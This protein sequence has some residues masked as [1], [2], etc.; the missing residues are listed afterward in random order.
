LEGLNSSGFQITAT[1]PI[2]A[3]Q[4]WRMLSM[5][6][7]SLTS[8]I[9]L[10]CR[11]R[12]ENAPSI[13]RREYLQI[14]KRE[15]PQAIGVMQHTNLAPVDMAQATIG[16]GMG[17]FSRYDKIMEQD[18][19]SMTVRT[20]LT[21]INRT[22]DE[23]LAEQEGDFD[24][25]TRWAIAW[26]EQNQF[27][28]GEFGDAD[29]LCRAKNSAVNALV[30]AGIVQSGGG[31]VNLISRD[32]LP[33]K[34]NP[35]EDNHMV[36]WEITQHLIKQLQEN[37]ETGAARLYKK[38]GIKADVAREL[39]YRLFTICE[40]KGWSQEAQAYNSLVLSWNQIVAESYNIKESKP[41]QGN[42]FD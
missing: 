11:P 38:I 10:A 39:A 28:K 7:N 41:I 8:Y 32:V 27:E 30:H 42:L 17:I 6:T 24:S 2:K 12:P 29:A 9:V 15:L 22:L 13:T 4:K 36:I 20:A 23:L 26:F 18:G 19:S 31:K 33:E 14:L 16:P 5:G 1:W 34:W 35:Q 25:E 3:S 40:K 37:G 21:V